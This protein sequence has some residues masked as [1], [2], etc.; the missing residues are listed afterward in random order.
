[1]LVDTFGKITSKVEIGIGEWI[2][3]GF[4]MV[5]SGPGFAFL[6]WIR[7]SALVD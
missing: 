6:F 1:M 7:A 2:F 4:G 3:A 5:F